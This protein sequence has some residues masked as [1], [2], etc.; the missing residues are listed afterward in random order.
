MENEN[1]LFFL[2]LLYLRSGDL[3]GKEIGGKH[4]CV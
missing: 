3:K 4:F 1:K 2:F